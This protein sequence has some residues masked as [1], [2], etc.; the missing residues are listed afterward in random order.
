MLMH[1]VARSGCTNTV[2][3]S[4]LQEKS[5]NLGQYCTWL[6]SLTLPTELSPPHA[7]YIYIDAMSVCVKCV[8]FNR[9]MP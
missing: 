8:L 4:A 1:A 6:F 2:R 9:E 3:E 7:I 5:L